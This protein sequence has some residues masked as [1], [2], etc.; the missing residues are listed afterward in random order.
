M[1]T[2]DLFYSLPSE[3]IAQTPAMPRDS[4]RL[5][6]LERLT[7]N[8]EHLVFRDI[9]PFLKPGDLLVLNDTRVIPARLLARKAKTGGKVEILLLDP[10]DTHSWRALVRGKRVGPQVVLELVGKTGEPTGVTARVTQ[11]LTGGQRLVVFSQPTEEWL[12]KLGHTPLPP[13]IRKYHGDPERYQTVYAKHNGS[14]AA[15]TAGLHFTSDL[16][17]D[18]RKSGINICYVNLRIGLDTFKPI[19]EELITE[20]TI[21]TEWASVKSET[22]RQINQTKLAGGRIIAVGTTA[23][24]AIETAALGA[25]NHPKD[26]QTCGWSTIQAFEGPTDLYITPGFCFRVVDAMVTNFHL[27]RSTLLALVSAFVGA[28]DASDGLKRI[29]DAYQIAVARRYRFFSFGDAMLIL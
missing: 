3:L 15:P 29:K 10:H 13:Y 27:P 17:I 11:I 7:G 2:A 14:V 6:V 19:E 8:I 1:R 20:H 9:N 16:L 28:M 26:S 12:W 4:A 5:M 22:A 24:R 21:H 25:Q 18:I 23:V